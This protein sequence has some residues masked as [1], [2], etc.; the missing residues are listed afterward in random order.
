MSV[1]DEKQTSSEMKKLLDHSNIVNDA[2]REKELKNRNRPVFVSKSNFHG[3][4]LFAAEDIYGEQFVLNYVAGKIRHVL[5]GRAPK[6]TVNFRESVQGMTRTRPRA[7]QN[8]RW[9]S[10]PA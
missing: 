2:V 4:G 10:T 6:E 1:R 7:L 9:Y 3:L 8:G 5:A